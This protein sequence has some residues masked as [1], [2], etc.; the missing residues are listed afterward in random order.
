MSA[1][2]DELHNVITDLEGEGHTLAGRFRDLLDRIKA[3]FSHLVGGG[4]GELETF[5]ESLV[6][7]LVPELNTVKGQIVAEV[8]AEVRK[9]TDEVKA[10]VNGHSEPAPA[11]PATPAPA[12][13]EPPAAPAQG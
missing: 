6:A 12:P 5:V 8:I 10:V 13:V 4:K 3:D 1:A 11:Q 9:V 2:L 7:T